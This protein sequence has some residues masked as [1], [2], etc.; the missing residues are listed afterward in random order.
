MCGPQ[1]EGVPW[2]V[3]GKPGSPHTHSDSGGNVLPWVL[4]WPQG[5]LFRGPVCGETWADG[6]H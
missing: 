5:E 4:H 3:F 6:P 2:L 1:E